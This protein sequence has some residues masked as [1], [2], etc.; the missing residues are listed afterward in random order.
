MRNLIV[1]AVLVLAA[2][3]GTPDEAELQKWAASE[4]GFTRLAGVIR[5]AGQPIDVRVRAL[6]IT[7]EKGQEL[8]VR[9]M[10]EL[11]SDQSDREAVARALVDRLAKQIESRS[12]AQVS[13]KDAILMLARYLTPEQL[14][15]A[16]RVIA[17]WA[18]SDITWETSAED[19]KTKLEARIS[20]SQIAELGSYGLEGAAILLANGFIAE[21]MARYISASPA[22]EAK[23]LLLK[24][25]RRFFPT[26][27]N[28]NPFYLDS[29]RK[30]QDPDGAALLFQIYQDTKFEQKARDAA[31]SVGAMMVDAPAIKGQSP[32]ALVD[33]LVKIGSTA[34]VEDRWLAAANLLVVT[35]GAGLDQVLALFKD[36]KAYTNPEGNGNAVLD[37]CF[38][39]HKENKPA[40]VAPL[41]AKAVADGN[42][43]QKAIAILCTKTL[44]LADAK[45]ALTAIAAT[46][47]KADTAIDD[48]LGPVTGPDAKPAPLTLGH[49]A[50]NAIEG[51]D[52][53]VAS[54]LESLDEAK[55]KARHFVIAVEFK[56]L[57]EVYAKSIEERY[58]ASL[59]APPK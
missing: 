44:A 27:L 22:P 32:K 36:D 10:L 24:A 25:F 59:A 37:L 17:A 52:H 14:D 8:R 28:V 4:Q 46:R 1:A 12:A 6:E 3:G 21:Q 45:P 42:R 41:L 16:Q 7:V 31:F 48:F 54:K 13:S 57:G 55:R 50:Q 26:F 30:T 40:A 9:N 58:N 5:D 11:I 29:I 19:L 47:G 34:N 35:G 56:E 51:I 39:L 20:A 23:S 33:E 2:C 18:F 53:L 43:I 15:R 49:L 38:E